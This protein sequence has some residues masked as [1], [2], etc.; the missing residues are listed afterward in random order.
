MLRIS[1]RLGLRREFERREER[2]IIDVVKPVEITPPGAIYASPGGAVSEDFSLREVR[3]AIAPRRD[4]FIGERPAKGRMERIARPT[5]RKIKDTKARESTP[6]KNF[7]D[8]F[9]DWLNKI[10]SAT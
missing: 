6:A 4:V 7:I 1:E 9:F 10:L 2:R 3:P 5:P 8:K